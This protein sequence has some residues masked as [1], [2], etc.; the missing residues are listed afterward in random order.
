[1]KAVCIRP[2]GEIGVDEI[3]MPTLRP[4]TVRIRV[5]AAA[6]NP[7]DLAMR[8]FGRS[9]TGVD[10]P[11]VPGM[12]VAGVID[13][14][15]ESS[16]LQIGQRVMA[17]VVPYGEQ[18][19]GQA[20]YVV[21]PE[22]SVAVIDDSLDFAEAATIPMNALTARM[23]LVEMGL[24]R[25]DTVAV[26]GGAGHLATMFT[27]MACN[28]G[29]HVVADADPTEA[30]SV[31]ARG[32][33]L[34]FD[35]GPE[36]AERIRESYRDGVAAVLDTALLGADIVRAVSDGGVLVTVRPGRI[37]TVRGIDARLILVS[38]HATN[39]APM[40]SV[41]EF[42]GEGVISGRVADVYSPDR[43]ADAYRRQ[44]AGGVRGRLVLDFEKAG[45]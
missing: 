36:L 13:S 35:R 11:W 12:D 27:L 37:A 1:M 16:S 32:V 34:V 22:S 31:R 42:V 14:V 21:V 5:A 40:R 9:M 3:P 19:G 7:A 43:V 29:L 25:G 24:G 41:A 28:Q 15:S 44:A 10:G 23:A 45:N 38:N 8:T 20:E 39:E 4:G 30:D 18:T 6:V 17:V 33:E 2:D 26:T